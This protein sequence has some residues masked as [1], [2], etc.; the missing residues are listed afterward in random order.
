MT[1]AY[2]DQEVAKTKHLSNEYPDIED[3]IGQSA[4]LQYMVHQFK[5]FVGSA[6]N[7]GIEFFGESDLP[8]YNSTAYLQI[9]N[10]TTHQWDT[11]DTNNTWPDEITFELKKKK[12][13][14]TNYKNAQNIISCR[15]YQ[16]AI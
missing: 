3:D 10:R 4:Q 9:Y 14:L 2:T 12:V 6:A 7:C 13:D 8:L 15:V 5:N 16:R 11:L 1:T